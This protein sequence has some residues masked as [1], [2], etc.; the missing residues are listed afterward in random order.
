MA[1]IMKLVKS[2]GSKT[3]GTAQQ[4]LDKQTIKNC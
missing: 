3:I 1:R 4:T 2:F